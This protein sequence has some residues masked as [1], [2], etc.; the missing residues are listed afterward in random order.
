MDHFSGKGWNKYGDLVELGSFT[1]LQRENGILIG[2]L[3]FFALIGPMVKFWG[4]GK[5]QDRYLRVHWDPW[6][7]KRMQYTFYAQLDGSHDGHALIVG[8]R[9]KFHTFQ[10]RHIQYKPPRMVLDVKPLRAKAAKLLST[11]NRRKSALSNLPPVPKVVANSALRRARMRLAD[12]HVALNNSAFSRVHNLFQAVADESQQS[13]L[14]NLTWRTQVRHVDAQGLETDDLLILVNRDMAIAI[15]RENLKLRGRF[16][17]AT[18]KEFVSIS[19]SAPVPELV[20]VTLLTSDHSEVS[21]AEF[22]DSKHT[23]A[24]RKTDDGIALVLRWEQVAEPQQ[25]NVVDVEAIIRVSPE[26]MSHWSCRVKNRSRGLGLRY[27]KFPV[28]DPLHA[29]TDEDPTDYNGSGLANPTA[30]TGDGNLG[31][32]YYGSRG[33]V[34]YHP[35]DSQWYESVQ[36]AGSTVPREL[37][38]LSIP[39][40]RS[41]H[42]ANR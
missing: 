40:S 17:P 24:W 31:R 18:E 8:R 39:T 12:D 5:S 42:T 2:D 38:H 9:H 28:I 30:R 26:G 20:A 34:Y 22:A 13:L 14:E 19:G 11:Y 25:R 35:Q 33:G 15:D 1:T 3:A 16:N 10:R 21:A 32:A 27:I 7:T 23:H 29:G 41:I 6:P 36:G 37:R 4:A